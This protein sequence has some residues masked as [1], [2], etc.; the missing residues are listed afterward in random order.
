M[1]TTS[2]Y[3]FNYDVP[4]DRSQLLPILN[5]AIN[6]GEYRF[7]RQTALSWLAAYPGDLGINLIYS[8]ALFGENKN[9]YAIPILESMVKLDPEFEEAIEL[10]MLVD[11]VNQADAV[12]ADMAAYYALTGQVQ[13][14][15]AAPAWAKLALDARICVEKGD[16]DDA[17]DL[18]QQSIMLEPSSVLSAVTHLRIL[19]G[20]KEFQTLKSLATLYHNR[21]PEVIQFSLMLAIAGMQDGEDSESV[22]L[23]HKVVTQDASGQV[24]IRLLGENHPYKSLWPAKME[25]RFSQAVPSSVA[26]AL[27][28]N[29][30]DPGEI[31][32]SS[33]SFPTVSSNTGG[34]A[35]SSSGE[36]STSSTIS[37]TI[38]ENFTS[39][40][41]SSDQST[42]TP[43]L[44]TQAQSSASEPVT[45]AD[46]KE[47]MLDVQEA[48]EKVAQRIHAPGVG[49][50][51][52]RFPVYVIFTSK[53]GLIKQYGE[54]S[55]SL[56][57][58]QLKLLAEAV[59]R[60]Q[61]WSSLLFY[62]D[63][64][65]STSPF[66]IQPSL[67]DPWKL[68]LQLKDLDTALAKKG[69][70]IGA[71]LIVGGPEIIPFHNLPNPTDDSD[72][73]IPSD[74]PY[75]TLDDNYFI[76]EWQV[77]R[78]P[79]GAEHKPDVLMKAIKSMIVFHNDYQ[80]SQPWWQNVP[81]FAPIWQKMQT[82]LPMSHSPLIAKPSF[83]Y[84]AAV[85][86]QASIEV[87]RP[88]GETQ[89]I[90]SSP[91]GKTGQ[92]N[93][94]GYLP[95]KL[96]YFNLHGLSDSAYWYGQPKSDG[97]DSTPEYP[98]A[99]SPVDL[100]G[101]PTIP[102]V[103]FSEACYGA[104]INSKGVNDAISL[105]FLE[106]GAHAVVGSTRIAYG[107]ISAPLIGADLLGAN[108]W[109]LMK[110]GV[111]AG[112]AL[113]TAKVNL[114]QEM[115]KSQGFLDGEDQ[116]T[117]ISFVL[118]G[119]PLYTLPSSP[120][121][122]KAAYRIRSMLPEFSL[123]RSYPEPKEIQ[124]ASTEAVKQVKQ[125]V[126]QYLPGLRDGEYHVSRQHAEYKNMSPKKQGFLS[127]KKSPGYLSTTQTV[128]TV[129]KNIKTDYEHREFARFTF[130][131][132]GKV[133][134]LAISH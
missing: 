83:G 23:L 15:F 42:A 46:S 125:I 120:K 48:L 129:S 54:S 100:E 32:P 112:E 122:A 93:D 68:K 81:F 8:K 114:A 116:K 21:W 7:V 57:D 45:E 108:F 44:G 56:I 1:K 115:T 78:V 36:V 27:G 17:E 77:G 84:T 2:A 61:G 18:V 70:M 64:S 123:S 25:M 102:N 118:Y 133:I 127:R 119:D 104:Y 26:G 10:K 59:R 14:G 38:S 4:V 88:I 74:N 47:E 16:L 28:W 86:R 97:Q 101:C 13:S 9:Q 128:I 12:A 111:T 6:V 30:L 98:V 5:A 50:V 130:A 31:D 11:Q 67:I 106:R 66:G 52:G 20:R 34:Q 40:V 49:R 96:A 109:K 37:S 43:S 117:L 41:S 39:P 22:A 92:I 75:S 105:K 121:L 91:P 53:Q 72:A 55:A 63:D 131:E 103:I 107:S 124:A 29:L 85:W 126:E 132:D 24:A 71:L 89:A 3:S 80:P 134:K 62:A 87:F 76:P 58:E 19:Y 113:R 60:H 90:L 79:G 82:V 110:S 69:E 95:A 35:V 33:Q 65:I 94:S 51:D 73:D 99:L